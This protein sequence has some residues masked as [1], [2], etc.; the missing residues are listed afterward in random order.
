MRFLFIFP[1]GRGFKIADKKVFPPYP[2]SPPLGILYLSTMLERS[3]HTIEVFDYTAENVDEEKLK[4]KI[5]SVDAVGITV[6]T[7]SLDESIKLAHLIKKHRPEIPLLIGGPHC[8]LVPEK[9]L[10]DF[11][12]DICVT[13]DG[14]LIIC[15]IADALQ[16]KEDLSIIPGVYYKEG[17]KVKQGGP[18]Q[19]IKDLDSLPFPDRHL[20]DKYDYGYFIGVKLAPGRTTSIITTRGCPYRCRFCEYNAVR[21]KYDERSVDNVIKEIE[22]IVAQGFHSLI[23]VDNN[24]L[25]NKKRAE[26]IMDGII[27]K[28]LKINIWIMGARVDSAERRLYGKLRDA[29]VSFISF[30]I[31]SGNQDVLD[32][33]N[34]RTTIQ[35]IRDAVSISKE[36][37]FFTSGSFVIGSEI[38]TK[39]H[40]ENTLKFAKSLPLDV[41]HF[42]V[43]G[44]LYGSPLWQ[45]AVEEGKIRPDEFT[46][47]ADSK[48]NLSM[49][50]QEELENY[51]IK[52]HRSFYFDPRYII[53]Q[54]FYA[55]RNRDFRFIK[56]GIKMFTTHEN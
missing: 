56:A 6:C 55:F 54:L 41:A 19:I 53:K 27:E 28:K 26:K 32:L 39:S 44:Y 1:P 38:E 29:G 14:E 23:I 46:V 4:S 47:N 50:T 15:K 5:D 31:E 24:F 40:I 42:L 35:Q 34:K 17:G 8:N 10:I 12:A 21:S 48:R 11:N 33:Y 13:G 52:A 37:G 20:V 16:G 49:F 7:S 18:A 51:C 2:Y 45:K 30:G 9:S 3:G 22:E 25:A 36:M 43:L